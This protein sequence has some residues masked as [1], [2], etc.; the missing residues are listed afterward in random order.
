[1]TFLTHWTL[2]HWLYV[3]VIVMVMCGKNIDWLT[4][5]SHQI[6][7]YW[8]YVMVMIVCGITYWLIVISHSL[9]PVLLFISYGCVWCKIFIDWHVSLTRHFFAGFNVLIMVMVMSVITYLLIDISISLDT[10]LLVIRYG[11]AYDYVWYT[12]LI[13]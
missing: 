8:L 2:Y 12:I 13:D 10:L 11:Y 3:W 1:M 4:F 6:L 7:Y 9:D 5:L